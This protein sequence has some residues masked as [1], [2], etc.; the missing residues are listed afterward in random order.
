MVGGPAVRQVAARVTRSTY[1]CPNPKP[2]ALQYRTRPENILCFDLSVGNS[3]NTSS[4]RP[5]TFQ[6][7]EDQLIK[8]NG[9]CG[10]SSCQ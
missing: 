5:E 2:A 10:Y 3:Q 6:I 9:S 1:L 8:Y 4:Y 7:H